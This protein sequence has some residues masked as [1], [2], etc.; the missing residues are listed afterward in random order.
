MPRR[1]RSRKSKIVGTRLPRQPQHA[2]RN[3]ERYVELARA[4]ALKGD[5]IAAENYLQHA[6]H[7]L[8]SMHD[9]AHGGRLSPPPAIRPKQRLRHSG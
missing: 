8:R 4:E 1:T 7:Y 3:Y 9:E 5:L 6:E 2:Q